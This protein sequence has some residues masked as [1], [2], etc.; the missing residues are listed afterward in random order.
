MT[1]YNSFRIKDLLAVVPFELLQKPREIRLVIRAI[2]QEG[3]DARAIAEFCE[4]IHQC[5]PSVDL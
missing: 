3:V 2:F 5:A 4:V 1:N